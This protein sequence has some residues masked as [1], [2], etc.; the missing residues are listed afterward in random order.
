VKE[1]WHSVQLGE[2]CTFKYGKALPES[3]RKG[4]ATPVYG[5][6]GIVGHHDSSISEGQTII[7]GRKGSFGEINL[8]KI[9]CWPI[10]TA[11]Y[12]DEASTKEDISWL[13]Y[14]LADLG[15][16]K[17]NKAAAVPGLNREDAYRQ[18]LLLPPLPE[19]RRIAAILDQA[20][21]LRA[22]RREALAQLDKLAQAIFVEMFGDPVENDMA[23]PRLAVSDFVAGF[24]SGKS[25]AAEDE[26]NVD[27][28]YRVIKISAVT[29]LE[30]RPER[31][32]AVP[33]G[34]SPP[35]S[36][37]VRKGDLLFSRANTTE[38]I[39]ATAYVSET[40]DNMLLPD[41]IWRFVWFDEPRAAPLYVRH[42]FQQL[43][44]RQEIG[45]RA[46]GTSGSMQNISQPKVLSI[47]V[48][49]PPVSLQRDFS[50]RIESL[51]AIKATYRAS[52]IEFSSLFTSL[53]HRAFRGEL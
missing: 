12:I 20:D 49:H 31:S 48:G 43:K 23:W 7:V 3:S 29:S 18:E 1:G 27:S 40:P 21:A 4:G 30:Y 10:D 36:H 16:N 50:K 6:N 14:R 42:L 9:P 46:S 26:E 24:E 28:T 11:Y 51:E 37:I 44:F 45:R 13:F 19:Q 17:L 52:L 35:M 47:Q 5:S 22:K 41:K 39:G 8:S 33:S 53:Q 2:I 34:Y 25:L 15:L 38:L 32:K